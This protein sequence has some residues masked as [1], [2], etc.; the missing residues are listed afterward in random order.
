MCLF[1][2]ITIHQQELLAQRERQQLE[3]H[4]QMTTLSE[5]RNHIRILDQALHNAQAKVLQF[6]QEVTCLIASSVEFVII[7][8]KLSHAKL[9]AFK[10]TVRGAACST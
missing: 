7:S 5:Q 2:T 4:V 8:A 3:Q 6:E 10:E 9:G 1:L